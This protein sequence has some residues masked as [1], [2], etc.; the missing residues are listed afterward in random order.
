M[1]I[2][3]SEETAE[4]IGTM[5]NINEAATLQYMAGYFFRRLLK[6]HKHDCVTCSTHG[7]HL[8]AQTEQP[9]NLSLGFLYLKRYCTSEAKLYQCTDH[10]TSYVQGLIQIASRCFEDYMD[11][12]GIIS[13]AAQTGLHNLTNVPEFCS[14]KMHRRFAFLVARTII[15]NQLKWR[16]SENK[17]GK[18]VSKR[19]NR[20]QSK[21]QQKLG[22]LQHL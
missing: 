20:M 7:S 9:Q 10:F 2:L 18:K 12:P 19:Q 3:S 1:K 11:V 4:V 8:T 14:T 5:F 22:K 6:Y 17:T 16:N 15:L 13:L 21:S